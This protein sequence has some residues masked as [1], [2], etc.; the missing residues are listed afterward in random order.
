[1]SVSIVQR[2]SA[3]IASG[4]GPFTISFGSN[5]VPGNTIF[6]IA[7][8]GGTGSMTATDDKA[9]GSNTY[10]TDVSLLHSGLGTGWIITAP[11]AGSA[12]VITLTL[13]V[14]TT[15]RVIIYEVSGLTATPIDQ[16]SSLY[17]AAGAATV[18]SGSTP[19]TTQASEWLLG[20][21]CG[22]AP[23]TGITAGTSQSYV[24]EDQIPVNPN[25]RV[26][27]EDVTVSA[28]GAFLADFGVTTGT[29]HII[30][31][32]TYKIAA[33]APSTAFED[34]SFSVTIGAVP[35]STVSIW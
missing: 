19:T 17:T 13:S 24:L 30:L 34:D 8:S 16:V 9:G 2:N 4:A 20:V 31:L 6:V 3:D 21:C 33:V 27:T 14:A 23:E 15:I 35:P 7:R 18:N 11:N 25:A 22:N 26:S 32:A 10:N 29:D 5:T 1:M 12:K 28:T